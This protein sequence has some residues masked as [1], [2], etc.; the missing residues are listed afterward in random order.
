MEQ[1]EAGVHR[2]EEEAGGDEGRLELND[3][4]VILIVS[5]PGRRAN[6]W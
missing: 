6:S 1:Q 2:G 3:A 5:V 4:E